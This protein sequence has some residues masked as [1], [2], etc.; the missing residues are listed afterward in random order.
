MRKRTSSRA[1]MVGDLCFGYDN[2]M[3]AVCMY[4]VAGCGVSDCYASKMTVLVLYIR[5]AWAVD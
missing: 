4:S 5:C 1:A 3:A 2:I